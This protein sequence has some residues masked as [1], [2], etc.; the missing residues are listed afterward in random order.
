MHVWTLPGIR[1]L[2]VQSL[3]SSSNSLDN[4]YSHGKGSSSWPGSF[5]LLVWRRA[6]PMARGLLVI[7]IMQAEMEIGPIVPSVPFVSFTQLPSLRHRA[8]VRHAV[9]KLMSSAR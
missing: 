6:V 9:E 8:V 7:Q 4:I 2:I 1:V 3:P 5:D